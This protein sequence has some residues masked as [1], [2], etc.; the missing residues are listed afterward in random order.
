MRLILVK[1]ALVTPG[2]TRHSWQR[3]GLMLGTTMGKKCMNLEYQRCFS[4]ECL[5]FQHTMRV[6]RF[7]PSQDYPEQYSHCAIIPG[8]GA[9]VVVVVCSSLT[10]KW[11]LQTSDSR[12]HRVH[13]LSL[14]D[15][16]ATP[17]SI[18]ALV[19]SAVAYVVTHSTAHSRRVSPVTEKRYN[20]NNCNCKP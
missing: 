9:D 16:G 20:L 3:R 2:S 6:S 17:S 15:S 12:V 13:F 11:S 14:T 1:Y 18:L 7:R 5:D 19:P 8:S 4:R 10:S